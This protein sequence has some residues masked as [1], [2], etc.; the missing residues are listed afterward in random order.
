MNRY[1]CQRRLTAD[2]KFSNVS[3][4]SLDPAAVGG[5]AITRRGNLTVRFFVLLIRLLQPLF[6]HF[7]P[8]GPLR[9]PQKTARDMHYVS[10]DEETLGKHPKALYVDG[11][12]IASTSSESRDEKKQG[13]LWEGSLRIAGVKEGD[14]VL[15]DWN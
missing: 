3:I 4:L 15:K 14:T 5:T 7:W 9:T 8:N 2:P 6:V 10:F 1:E 12:R 11:T 13:L